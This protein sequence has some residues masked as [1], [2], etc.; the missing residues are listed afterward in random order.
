MIQPKKMTN[1][2]LHLFCPLLFLGETYKTRVHF[3]A[4][5][6][7]FYEHALLF[8][9]ETD[10][11]SSNLQIMRLLEIRHRMSPDEEPLPVGPNSQQTEE[12][13]AVDRCNFNIICITSYLCQ[14]VDYA[15][16]QCLWNNQ[17]ILF[18]IFFL[19]SVKVFFHSASNPHR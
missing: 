19:L 1:W 13:E 3:S 16:H 18:C 10:S 8:T 12:E 7:G 6:P 15:V 14:C 17:L 5:Y 4:E 9:F 11:S 2:F